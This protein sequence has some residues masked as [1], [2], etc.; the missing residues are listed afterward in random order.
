MAEFDSPPGLRAEEIQAE[1]SGALIGRHIVVL[2]EATSTNDSIL[3]MANGGAPE[4]LV[5]FAEHQDAGRGQHGNRWESPARLGLWF[6]ILLRP[7]IDL[8]ESARLTTWAAGTVATTITNELSLDAIVKP[9][10]DVYVAG[11]K[12]AGVLVEMRAQE[13][14][15]HLAIVGIGI[16]VHQSAQDFPEE[17]R[18]RAISLAM[19]IGREVNRRKF[20]V[21]LLRN[22]ERTYGA[23]VA[24]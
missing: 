19:A 10:N 2:E 21:A 3:Q 9:P 4:G 7:K 1:V 6:S 15:S 16:N 17:I 23:A 8:T 5:V 12:V 20:A 14:A 18:A 24:L 11:R 13:G 22:L